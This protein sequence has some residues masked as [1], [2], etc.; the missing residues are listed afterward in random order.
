MPPQ[1]ARQAAVRSPDDA[2]ERNAPVVGVAAQGAVAH[3]SPVVNLREAERNVF[4]RVSAFPHVKRMTGR[5]AQA[6]AS[7]VLLRSFA[8][9]SPSAFQTAN[10]EVGCRL[11][12]RWMD[13]Q[14]L[15]AWARAEA[16]R[17]RDADLNV[18]STASA[19][20]FLRTHGQGAFYEHA[21]DAGETASRHARTGAGD[22]RGRQE[23][24]RVLQSWADYIEA[25]L[26]SAVPVEARI[27]FEAATD[28]MEQVQSL[29]DDPT[30]IAAAPVMLAGAA[31]EESLRG[32]MIGCDHPIVGA[33]SISK[34]SIALRKCERI[35]AHR[36]FD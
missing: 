18:A 27:R 10:G 30:V 7:N 8:I 31:L 1:F 20:E 21:R 13:E 19:V 11:R 35:R 14:E 2:K 3:I 25:G 29:L 9:D 17:L 12:Y 15:V 34:Y 23:V 32:L 6:E 24:A 4:A 36:G 33:P 26:G 5:S 16:L 22:R 28:L